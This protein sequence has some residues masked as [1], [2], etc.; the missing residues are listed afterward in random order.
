MYI[1]DTSAHFLLENYDAYA[2]IFLTLVAVP[3]I[4]GEMAFTIWLL[5]KG[6]K[7]NN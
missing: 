7:N 2:G 6:G 5:V 4:L 3:S 1:V